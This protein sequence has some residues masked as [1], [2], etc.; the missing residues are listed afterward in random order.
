MNN[1]RTEKIRSD[2]TREERNVY[3]GERSD[4]RKKPQRG[5]KRDW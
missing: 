1:Q 4:K 3:R 5:K 2:K